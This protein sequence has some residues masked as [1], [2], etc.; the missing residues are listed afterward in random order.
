MAGHCPQAAVLLAASR[1]D[2][3]EE[4]HAAVRSAVEPC[5]WLNREQKNKS[6][7]AT[8]K[9]MN[10]VINKRDERESNNKAVKINTK[11]SN[12]TG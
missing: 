3:R 8:Y 7:K 11:S 5:N 12:T 10:I 1:S 4:R 9:G 2:G 6:H